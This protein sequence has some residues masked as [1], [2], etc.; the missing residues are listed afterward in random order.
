MM[1]EIQPT[2]PHP[3]TRRAVL[4]VSALIVALLISMV[5]RT[6]WV[7]RDYPFD[8]DEAIHANGALEMAL[9]LR[10]GDVEAFA[11]TFYQ[12]GFYPPAFSVLKAIG[13]LVFGPSPLVARAFSL[14]CLPVGLLM[15]YLTGRS[16]DETWGWL[17]GVIAVLLTL[18][19]QFLLITS[20]LVMMEVPGLLASFGL[21]W[22]YTEALER[23]TAGRLTGTGLMLAITFLTKYTYGAAAVATVVLMEASRF[24]AVRSDSGASDRMTRLRGAGR[25]WAWLL[26]P[27]L[28]IMVIWFARPYKIAEFW[29]YATAQ[30]AHRS[31]SLESLLFYPRSIALHH[32]PSPL[33]AV[34]MLVSLF[35][36]VGRWRSPKHRLLLIYFLVGMGE[37]TLN[38]P[39]SPR[40]ICTFVPAAHLLTGAMIVWCF[41]RSGR[42]ALRGWWRL[43]VLLLVVS[44]LV[45]VPVLSE[46]YR[47]YPSLM[48]V[49]YETHPKLNE[50]A[51]WIQSRI[52][53]GE[54]FYVINFWD[55]MSPWALSWYFGTH[56][57]APDLRFSD[58]SMPS[59]LLKEASPENIA[60]LREEILVSDVRYLVSFEG[61]PWGA[62]VWW[63]Y[64]GEM[65]DMLRA[66]DQ[67]TLYVDLYDT[68][69][70]LKRS[71]LRKGPW[72]RVKADGRFTLQVT[73]TVYEVIQP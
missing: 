67:T 49:A 20:G 9:D 39:N 42:A 40:F 4:F 45:S 15:I 35:W 37:M 68:G 71:L 29:S 17:I 46:R 32:S 19:S 44:L 6:I 13:F 27:F 41:S 38:S 63:I 53:S 60:S 51:G 61:A 16:L 24:L 62:P 56:E 18:T 48:E 72:E 34:I 47:T 21:L 69:G 52:P 31:W 8:A 23:P 22:L 70:W 30:P 14:F 10:A 54:R 28:L 65:S 59:A 26:G 64:A 57:V 5:A 3:A 58:V 1:S 50:L 66:V 7:Y 36:A 2:V 11:R 55:Q 73:T 43:L 25:R 12:Q 33:F